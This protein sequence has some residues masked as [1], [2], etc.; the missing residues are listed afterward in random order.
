MAKFR[1]T[2]PDG[3]SYEIN[4]PEGASDQDVLEFAKQNYT[5]A[6][7]PKPQVS[8]WESA[9]RGALQGL[10]FN[11][12]DEIIG[13]VKSLPKLMQGTDAFRKA[14]GE[15]TARQ[16]EYNKAAQEANP[17]TFLASEVAGGVI[18]TIGA[19][20]TPGAQPGAGANA[21]KLTAQA[22]SLGSRV[23]QSAKIG[24]GF[25]A[26]GG[27]GAAESA[28][29]ASFTDQA[30]NTVVGAG[31]GAVV[32]GAVGAA[33][34]PA[35][36]LAGAA[37]RPFANMVRARRDP[38]G[39]AA[40]KMAEAFE[41]DSPGSK[42]V[43]VP[44]ELYDE[45]NSIIA[46]A[47][48][49]NVKGKMRSA[50]N[51]PNDERTRFNQILD[52]RMQ[53][54]HTKIEGGLVDTLGDPNKFY[55]TEEALM[56]VQKVRAAP[57]FKKAF[58]APF[59]PDQDAFRSLF[60]RPTFDAI[61]DRVVR[62]LQD[63]GIPGEHG[64]D[65]INAVRPMEV[66]HRIKVELDKQISQAVKAKAKGDAGG[67]EAFDLNTLMTLKN[68]LRAAID[69][70]GGA[71]PKLYASALKNFGDD[72]S[73]SRALELGYDHAT[74]KEAPEMIR[75]AMDKM[76]PPEQ[77][78]YRMGV[79][80][81]W[82]EQNREGKKTADRVGRDWDSP[83]REMMLQAIARTP[84]DVRRF[85]GMLK[86]LMKQVETRRAAQGNSTTARQLLEAQEDSKPGEVLK[87]G[88]NL[89]TGNWNALLDTVVNK[90]SPLR[91]MTP[92]VSA[93]M[94]RILSSPISPYSTYGRSGAIG[95]YSGGDINLLGGLPQLNDALSRRATEG[96]T[97]GRAQNAL[98]GG[99][100]PPLTGNQ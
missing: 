14:A 5:K 20:M 27:A 89:L 7:P 43:A 35:L 53:Q 1:I 18:P 79:A 24:A 9:G 15:E 75:R 16:R 82:A 50:L 2:G 26:V 60:A 63:E 38:K 69:A 62:S 84:E 94:L 10:T 71:G 45:P 77:E 6:A 52:D 87:T 32:G 98:I 64:A 66:V 97:I 57:A 33:L 23:M 81:K 13:G 100:L 25:G 92:E 41:R 56:K 40:D 86:A 61:K 72:A 47:G 73:L 59:E 99:I 96:R 37:V 51:V 22:A 95:P 8:A 83:S 34:P 67:K 39:F 88:K 48:G 76:S 55:Q 3:A 17:G 74:G 49:E 29:D 44:R 70:S 21:A 11:W 85:S 4:A 28:P 93:E 91:G 42:N 46:D 78:L 90:T 19:I 54:Q 80:R 65:V 30:M 58:D 68:D 31:K 36:D 12:G